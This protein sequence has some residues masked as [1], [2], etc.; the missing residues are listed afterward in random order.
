MAH[1][2][3]EKFRRSIAKR[4]W[5]G[6]VK[7]VA[8]NGLW[9]VRDLSPSQRL[10]RR[11]ARAFDRELGVAT[12]E[13]I[14]TGDLEI[15]SADREFGTYHDPTPVEAFLP[16]L[17]ELGIEYERYIFI[18]FGSGLGRAVFLASRFPFRKIVGVE[19][20]KTLHERALKNLHQANRAQQKCQDIELLCA[21][22]TAYDF[23]VAPTVLY[24]ANPFGAEVMTR[25]LD[26][27]SRSLA[28]HPR[29]FRVIY[30]NPLLDSLL[31]ESPALERISRGRFHAVYRSRA[32]LAGR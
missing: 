8:L 25:V 31:A 23:P 27:I 29:D 20:S 19:Y 11:E 28:A 10:K 5:S 21:D 32:A 3:V 17:S 2:L 30:Y 15:E 7:L 26:N 4:G 6:T 9:F 1:D 22:A 24:M 14:Q 12:S 16:M 18:D 13:I